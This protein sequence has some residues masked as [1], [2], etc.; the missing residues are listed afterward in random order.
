MKLHKVKK[1]T[2]ACDELS[3]VE[4]KNIPP[5]RIECR[6]MES[7][8]SLFFLKQAEYNIRCSTFNVDGLVKSRKSKLFTSVFC[9][10]YL[11]FSILT[12]RYRIIY[13]IPNT[14]H[15]TP[16]TWWIRLFTNSSLLDVRCS[17]FDLP[18][19]PW[20]RCE[21]NSATWFVYWC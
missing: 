4:P 1:R 21:K 10:W 2:A 7:L 9:I 17:T 14:K 12:Y 19:M 3:R 20:W 11:V 13:F 6:R 18:A 5:R 16:N 8:R 15:E